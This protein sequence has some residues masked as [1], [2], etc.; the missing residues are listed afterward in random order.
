M[1]AEALYYNWG[2]LAPLP[3]LVRIHVHT[4]KPLYNGHLWGAKIWL[5][6]SLVAFVE[7]LFCT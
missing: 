2:D 5:L 6:Y 7:G 3:K 1:V 4:L